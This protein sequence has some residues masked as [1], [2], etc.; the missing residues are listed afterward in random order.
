MSAHTTGKLRVVRKSSL[1]QEGGRKS[2]W[3]IKKTIVELNLE[4]RG[5]E[6]CGP[7]VFRL[8]Q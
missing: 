5:F 6:R 3:A 4:Q 7:V 8:F 1:S 2:F